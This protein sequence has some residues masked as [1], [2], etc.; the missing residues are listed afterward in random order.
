MFEFSAKETK[1]NSTSKNKKADNKNYDIF[2]LMNNI[3]GSI[4]PVKPLYC[5]IMIITR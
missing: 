1:N 2:L 5:Y 4:S 3:R